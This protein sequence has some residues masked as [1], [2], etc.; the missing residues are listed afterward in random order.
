MK[1]I[2]FK[3]TKEQRMANKASLLRSLWLQGAVFPVI[4]RCHTSPHI[5]IVIHCH[6]L[7]HIVIYCHTL[8]VTIYGNVYIAIYCHILS[9]TAIHCMHC[10]TLPHIVIHCHTLPHVAIHCHILLQG[11]PS[12]MALPHIAPYH[13][14]C[15]LCPTI[16]PHSRHTLLYTW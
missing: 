11:F 8:H 3:E 9:Y 12:Y 13:H 6:I 5:N 15:L 1:K 2:A 4:W 16:K 14:L 7:P 10:H